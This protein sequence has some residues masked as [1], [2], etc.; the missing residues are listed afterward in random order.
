[1]H[2]AIP[3]NA[4]LLVDTLPVVWAFFGLSPQLSPRLMF[5]SIWRRMWPRGNASSSGCT[6]SLASTFERRRC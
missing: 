6:C 1:M 5:Y 3:P 4:G 2:D